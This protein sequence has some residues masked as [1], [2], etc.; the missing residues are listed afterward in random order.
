MGLCGGGGIDGMVWNRCTG[1]RCR[2]GA[3]IDFFQIVM[4]LGGGWFAVDASN[5]TVIMP[6]IHPYS[7]FLFPPPASSCGESPPH[8]SG[9]PRV[10]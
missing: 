3:C 1:D 10:A 2:K 9:R 5:R 8:R 4:N 7:P 6:C